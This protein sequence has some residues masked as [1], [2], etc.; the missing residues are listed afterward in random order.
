MH[1]MID[2]ESVLDK[3]YYE[4]THLHY[5]RITPSLESTMICIETTEQ[6]FQAHYSLTVQS[7]LLF[8]TTVG[9]FLPDVICMRSVFSY[10]LA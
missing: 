4:T 2:L 1:Y 7:V 5:V 10:N 3:R 9:F 6:N 8:S